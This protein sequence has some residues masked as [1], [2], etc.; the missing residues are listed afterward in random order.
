M[1][2]ED[3]LLFASIRQELDANQVLDLCRNSHIR[4]D[5]VFTI[6]DR[7]GVAPLVFV[8]LQHCHPALDSIPQDTIDQFERA[9]YTNIIVKEQLAGK[10]G[11]VLEF[12]NRKRVDVMLVKGAA[13]DIVVYSHPWQTVINN[14]V[15]LIL[16]P[17]QAEMADRSVVEF[18]DHY[19]ETGLQFEYDFFEHHDITFNGQL[20]V[21]F[22]RIWD[23]ARRIDFRGHSVWVMCPEDLLITACIASCRNRFFRLRHLHDLAEI[24]ERYPDLDW[25]QLWSKASAYR[26][27]N[28]VYAALSVA[29]M[30]GVYRVS[31]EMLSGLA[32]SSVRAA[33]IRCV[34]QKQSF[35]TLSELFSG[36][37]L[38][39]RNVSWGLLLT[40]LTLSGDQLIKRIVYV[41]LHSGSGKSAAWNESEN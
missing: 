5:V 15:D 13:L 21:D 7:H 18:L 14:D 39:G 8:N 34:I 28:I 10:I 40:Y 3:K 9:L 6:A 11:E 1:T 36:V 41:F 23:D 19:Q 35:V 12:L 24:L 32:V 25:E 4:W 16:R 27:N 20:S 29:R 22:Q 38:L 26:C 30:T 31:D 37:R 17:R 2:S 33:I